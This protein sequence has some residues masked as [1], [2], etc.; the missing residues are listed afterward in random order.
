MAETERQQEEMGGHNGAG[1][2]GRPVGNASEEPP[3]KV[4]EHKE[5]KGSGQIE[6]RD[7]P[8]S[9]PIEDGKRDPNGP[10]LGGG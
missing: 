6:G 4:T 7:L 3:P 10:W 8:P 2:A 1:A 9:E 5:H